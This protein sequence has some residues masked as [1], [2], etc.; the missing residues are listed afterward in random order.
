MSLILLLCLVVYGCAIGWGLSIWL[1]SP[2][3]PELLIWS[4]FPGLVACLPVV[5]IAVLA[6]PHIDD[7]QLGPIILFSGIP[8]YGFYLFR[9]WRYNR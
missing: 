5:L 6:N 7:K 9:R 2:E 8:S 1:D 4:I 3:G